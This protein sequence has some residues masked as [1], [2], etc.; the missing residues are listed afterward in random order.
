MKKII[1]GLCVLGVAGYNSVASA[2]KKHNNRL[3]KHLR[4]IIMQN[5][6][7]GNPLLNRTVPDIN[8]PQAQLGKDLFFSKS[9]GG[10]FDSACVAC[11]HP[12][13]GGG[14]NLS[15]PIGVEADDPDLLGVGRSNDLAL[16]NPEGGPPVPR[17]APTTFNVVAWDQFQFHDGRVESLAKTP[18]A[19]GADGSGIRTPDSALGVADPLAGNNLVQAQARFP[20][21]S[22]EEMKGFDHTAYTN[23]TIRELLAGR[24]GG[25]GNEADALGADR[26]AIW[27]EK[28]QTALD[29]PDGTAEEIITEQNVSMVIAEYERS[30]AFVNTPWKKYIE[31][32]KR[33]ISTNAK[34]GA[35]LFY[36]TK[37]EGGADCASCHQGDFFTDESFHNMAMPQIG[38]GKGDGIDGSKDFGRARETGLDA[39]K[40]AFRTPSLINVEVTGPWSHAGSYTSLTAVVKHHLNPAQAIES[41]D[42]SLLAQVDIRNLDKMTENTTEALDAGSFFAQGEAPVLLNDMQVGFI[43]EFL[44]ALTDPCTQDRACLSPWIPEVDEQNIDQLNARNREGNLL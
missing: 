21:T 40:F 36:S 5:N 15:L 2:G 42:A 38:P 9:L 33:A 6:L 18:G 13:L 12:S 32:H 8:S 41:Y 26:L 23:Q 3:D 25:Y 16:N 43:V 44:Q 4:S 11:H 14:D 27:L 17:N 39:D 29:R 31:G 1:I 30:Q 28:F 20:V 24:L 22:N 7:T 19:N 10:D 34:R 37:A 35:V